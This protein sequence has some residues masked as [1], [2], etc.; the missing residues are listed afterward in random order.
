VGEIKIAVDGKPLFNWQGD[1]AAVANILE[2]FPRGAKGVGQSA[3]AFAQT[4]MYH[5]LDGR[6]ASSDKVGQ[7]MQMMGVT[8]LILT[9]D[10]GHPDHPGKI[11]DYVPHTD[12]AVESPSATMPS[13][14]TSKRS[15]NSKRDGHRRQSRRSHAGKPA[16]G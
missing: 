6:L 12:F 13:N 16:R 2:A 9:R 3:E 4:C 7:E 1:E 8:W 14:W 5:L 15:L 10:T 11:G